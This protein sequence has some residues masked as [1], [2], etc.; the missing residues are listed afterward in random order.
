MKNFIRLILIVVLFFCNTN[1][2]AQ[3]GI[4]VSDPDPSAI[5]HI[6]HDSKGVLFP[7]ISNS[8]ALDSVRGLFFYATDDNK[9]YY[10]DST[11]WQCV[12][13][14]SSTSTDNARLNGDLTVQGNLT[15][16]P[17]S[18]INGYG[19]I[20]MGGIIM[21][22]GEHDSIPNGWVLCNGEKVNDI[23]TPDLRGRFIVGYS[24]GH[25]DYGFIDSIGGQ[26]SFEL[27]EDN[28]PKHNHDKGNLHITASGSHTH[29]TNAPKQ[30]G[31]STEDG[32]GH[33]V[34][35]NGTNATINSN[36]HTHPASSFTGNT[37]YWGTNQLI[38]P[39]YG[40]IDTTGSPCQYNIEK[41]GCTDRR[42][43]TNYPLI[44]ADCD[45]TYI[46]FTKIID[47]ET[48]LLVLPIPTPDSNDDFFVNNPDCWNDDY[49]INYGKK[50]V[51]VEAHYG[52]VPVDNRPPYYVL[53]FII[54]V[55]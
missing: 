47:P 19:T 29:T 46:G 37:G 38:P 45:G 52:A 15:V 40:P 6:H 22:S 54:R 28:I 34:Q 33:H 43:F 42:P 24:T 26:E 8:A 17:E 30:E 9:F 55:K 41:D 1:A 13:P 23:Q 18:T 31:E 5:L 27:V 36:T 44:L 20:P 48:G 25:T 12:N 3:I 21:W 16:K 53:A 35:K 14:F 7:R 32:G 11:S 4:N 50:T 10:Y 51:I 49:N 39:V 2:W